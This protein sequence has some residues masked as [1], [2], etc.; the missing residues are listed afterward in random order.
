VNLIGNNQDSGYAVGDKE[1]FS[2]REIFFLG[3]L[4]ANKD[5]FSIFNIINNFN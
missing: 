4:L 2:W 5:S 3:I 1:M